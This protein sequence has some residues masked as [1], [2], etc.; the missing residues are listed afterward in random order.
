MLKNGIV[1]LIPQQQPFAILTI[2][3]F[4]RMFEKNRQVFMTLKVDWLGKYR[5]EP[6]Y[7]YVCTY[8]CISVNIREQKKSSNN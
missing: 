6:S 5:V 1:I 2:I 7:M 3:F 4:K 8:E